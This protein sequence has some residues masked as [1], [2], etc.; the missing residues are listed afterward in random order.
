MDRVLG[1]FGQPF[2]PCAPLPYV[3]PSWVRA[4]CADI[5]PTISRAVEA[6]GQEFFRSGEARDLI[7]VPDH[8][9]RIV[10]TD[11]RDAG[12]QATHPVIRVDTFID[13]SRR[14]IGILEFN[15]ADPSAFA[16]NDWMLSATESIN[17]VTEFIAAA[18]LRADRICHRHTEM[19]LAA[20]GEYCATRG[21]LKNRSPLIVLL[22]PATSS[23]YFDFCCLEKMLRS[24]GHRAMLATAGDLEV[25][26]TRAFCRGVPVDIIIRDTLDDVFDPLTGQTIEPAATILLRSLACVIN[27]LA[28]TIGD[29]KAIMPLLKQKLRTG[30]WG[31]QNGVD[32]ARL[33]RWLPET[34]MLG[35]YCADR[36]LREKDGWVL[37][38][39]SGY[40]GHG[41][42]PGVDCDQSTWN[43]MVEKLLAAA[44]PYVAQHYLPAGVGELPVRAGGSSV[45]RPVNAN[46]SFWIIGGH[47]AG[48]FVRMSDRTVINTHQ[49]GAL[50]PVYYFDEP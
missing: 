30:A 18:G 2:P 20:Y 11:L 36:V 12:Y 19:V 31:V 34:E 7:P 16:W 15:T 27:P 14:S 45:L 33:D 5:S 50:V 41:V 32:E 47:Y 42:Y 6:I 9:A 44:V 8:L 29:Q 46:Y 38:P 17:G 40:G 25:I 4:A 24:G 35:S 21:I 28:S 39:S 1:L 37:K 13:F 48:A 3:C 49:G 22:M 10:H 43:H 23:V 26:G